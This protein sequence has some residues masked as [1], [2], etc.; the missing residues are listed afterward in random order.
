M[1]DE[2]GYFYFKDRCGD[3]F[4]WKSENVSTQQVE[5][6]L[7]KICAL[8]DVAVYGVKIP[9]TEGRAGMAAI[10]DPDYKIDLT[11]F[12]TE[13]NKRLP[14]YSRP[15]FL[16]IK[17]ELEYTSKLKRS[18]LSSKFIFSLIVNFFPF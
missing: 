10:A 16:R 15:L 17:S 3:T 7:S 18:E 11:Q 2:L 1:M 13:V 5:S 14:G 6:V 8:K 9:F 12:A 4:R